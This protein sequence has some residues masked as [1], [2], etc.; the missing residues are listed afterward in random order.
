MT[1]FA[2]VAVGILA[3]LGARVLD[4]ARA[5]VGVGPLPA[6]A[7][8]LVPQARF[9]MGLD[10]KRFTEST[11]YR[12]YAT[13]GS[14][15]RPQP[16]RELEAK[17]GLNPER[18]VDHVFIAG[19]SDAKE[20]NAVLVLGR[21]DGYALG[22]AIENEKKE[23]AWKSFHGTTVYLFN[24]GKRSTGALAFLDDHTLV[25]GTRRTVES[26]IAH[27]S[28]V[29]P[30]QT[31]A[32]I[33]ELLGRVKPG[34]TFWM[35]GDESLL[36]NIPWTMAAPGSPSTGSSDS[37]LALPALKSL[38]LTGDLDPAVTLSITGNASDETAARSLADI[39]RGFVALASA[40]MDQKP[41]GRPLAS[42][43][44]VRTEASQVH[45]D[46]R[47]PYERLD[48]LMAFRPASPRDR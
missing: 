37:A 6:E 45:T 18:D 23:V 16:F 32:A 13:P 27:R 35:V 36:A 14:A 28:G 20:S 39:V 9:V 17:T 46:V 3:A 40:Q 33:L 21:F 4:P 29:P 26:V 8:V 1:S 11:F 22:R 42:E 47:L 38:V 10:V 24:E 44:V 5:A 41:E 31:N 34:S 25:F 19:G 2:L 43:V 7:L 12:K 30:P 48:A 15:T